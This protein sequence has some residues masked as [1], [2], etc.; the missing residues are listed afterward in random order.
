MYT[1]WTRHLS[2]PETKSQF[3]NQVKAAKPVLDR[4][5]QILEEKEWTLDRTEMN[6]AV[7]NTPNWDNRQAHKNGNREILWFLKTLVN[8]DQQKEPNHDPR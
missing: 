8:L 2:D 3:Q 7:Y 6:I 4:L 5:T 1:E